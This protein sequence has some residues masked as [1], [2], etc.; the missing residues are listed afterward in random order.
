[1]SNAVLWPLGLPDENCYR[2]TYIHTHNLAF[3]VRLSLVVLHIK[4]TKK[5][6]IFQ[7]T[8]FFNPKVCLMKIVTEPHTYTHTTLLFM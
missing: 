6:Q 4:N 5:L 8:Q 3:Y 1:M 7:S 2:H